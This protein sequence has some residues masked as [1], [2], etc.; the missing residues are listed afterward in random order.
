VQEGEDD[1]GRVHFRK[2]CGTG[3]GIVLAGP[4][5][6]LVHV[7]DGLESRG[8]ARWLG[9]DGIAQGPTTR[10]AADEEETGCAEHH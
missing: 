9:G 2:K 10:G 4:G 6:V 1:A 5:G 8:R 7:D 3:R